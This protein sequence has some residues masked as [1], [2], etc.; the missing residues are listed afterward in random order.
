[1]LRS[2]APLEGAAAG[3]VLLTTPPTIPRPSFARRLIVVAQEVLDRLVKTTID[4]LRRTK[5]VIVSPETRPR[6]ETPF[7]IVGA[8]RSG[9]TLLRLIV[10]SHPRIACPPESFFLLPLRELVRD[11]KAVEGLKAM[12]FTEE[13]V[14]ARLREWASYFFEM[15][16]AARGK[17]RWADKTPSY[18]DCLD[19]VDALYGPECRYVLVFRH[20]LDA[21]CSIAGVGP[22]ELAPHAE[23][24]GGDLFAGAARY[25]A[26]QCGKILDFQERHA[27]RCF[28]I[29][30]EELVQE[31]E[32]LLRRMFSFVDEAWD[33]RVLRFHE[34]PHDRWIGLEDRTASQARGISSNVGRYRS[35]PPH[36]IE[37]MVEQAGPM[38]A[39]LGYEVDLGRE[40][41]ARGT[42]A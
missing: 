18:V 21:A 5:R 30:Y 16:A 29:R 9:T 41:G 6:G 35:Q 20:G 19:F 34:H 11:A 31:P 36:V 7:F 24:C 3:R 39:R 17:V 1:V 37:R 22:R 13:H 25:W 32:P 38:L 10:D 12:G 23:A 42:G 8:H 27:E 14:L 2:A 26:T 28:E 33:P 15:Y 40:D 4:E